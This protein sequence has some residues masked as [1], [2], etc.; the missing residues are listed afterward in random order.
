MN[1]KGEKEHHNKGRGRHHLPTACS[2]RHITQRTQ[3][4]TTSRPVR[5]TTIT[6]TKKGSGPP[7][8][9]NSP[10]EN[11]L[12]CLLCFLGSF[13]PRL[14]SPGTLDR[15]GI[16]KRLAGKSGLLPP[17]L[18]ISPSSPLPLPRM[19]ASTF[20]S[21]EE[22]AATPLTPTRGRSTSHS[23]RTRRFPENTYTATTHHLRFP[24]SRRTRHTSCH[25]CLYFLARLQIHV[26]LPYTYSSYSSYSSFISSSFLPS[27]RPSTSPSLPPFPSPSTQ[28][29]H[30]IITVP[31]II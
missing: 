3:M 6:H 19:S 11:K 10:R 7:R 15:V 2:G 17:L 4:K 25:V 31:T 12:S 27:T 30:G 21:R 20:S 9:I 18:S 29:I 22:T 24:T 26:C 16:M 8:S 5:E 13:L 1:F 14:Q 28:F 23:M